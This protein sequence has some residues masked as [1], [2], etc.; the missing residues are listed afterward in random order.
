M[1]YI[2]QLELSKKQATTLQ[3]S[4]IYLI[5][6]KFPYHV[7]AGRSQEYSSMDIKMLQNKYKFFLRVSFK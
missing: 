7:H 5:K 2:I 6:T 3:A 4:F 1:E